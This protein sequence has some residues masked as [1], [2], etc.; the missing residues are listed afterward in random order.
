MAGNLGAL[1]SLINKEDRMS[2]SCLCTTKNVNEHQEK[3]HHIVGFYLEDTLQ[4]K[5]TLIREIDVDAYVKER[6]DECVTFFRFCPR[7][8]AEIEPPVNDHHRVDN[9][10]PV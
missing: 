7:C 3:C 10:R 9:W 4:L 2:P 1:K 6:L 5:G 8:G